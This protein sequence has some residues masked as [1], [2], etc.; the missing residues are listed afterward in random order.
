MTKNEVVLTGKSTAGSIVT[1]ES[2]RTYGTSTASGN[3]LTISDGSTLRTGIAAITTGNAENNRITMDSSTAQ[4][5]IAGEAVGSGAVDGNI[6]SLSGSAKVVSADGLTALD[7]AQKAYGE[8][9]G[10]SPLIIAGYTDSG[11]ASNNEVWASGQT[12][13][14]QAD[15]YGALNADGTKPSG[16]GNTFRVAYE[17]GAAGSWENP[18]VHGLYNF[19]K[20]A[21]YDMDP[22]K[23][24]LVITDTLD[25]P[26]DAELEIGDAAMAKLNG[27]EGQ[28]EGD[29]AVTING[30]P[31]KR[32]VVLIDASQAGTV[33]GL[34]SLYHNSGE[35]LKNIG[36]WNYLN[37]GV[38][39]TGTLGLS[40][41]DK[42]V[43]SYG[44]QSLDSITYRTIDWVTDGTALTLHTPENF[45]LA[46]TKVDTR[47]ISFTAS[48]LAAITAADQYTMTLLDTSGNTTLS[49]ANLSTGKGTWNIGNALVGT[50][51]AYLADN[52]NV[53]Y[54]MDVTAVPDTPVKPVVDATPQTHMWEATASEPVMWTMRWTA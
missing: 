7:D 9:T 48:S 26:S 16:S 40:L 11:T 23:A 53:L 45:N 35:S 12:D 32:P 36:T 8:V 29:A 47:D 24:G 46:N 21:L 4:S 19:D 22:Q 25:L 31:V 44:L 39:V 2:D 33:K 28:D 6:I 10:S 50:G 27:T 13:L 17:D 15:V 34:D 38:T 43:L 20:I 52:G 49:A 42:N 1:A 30:T 54:K 41:S 18:Q 5:L 3:K 37:G 51:E 14:S